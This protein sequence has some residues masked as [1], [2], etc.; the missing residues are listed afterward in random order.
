MSI[1]DL[2]TDPYNRRARL[3]PALFVML[4]ILL[5]GL[6]LYPEMEYVQYLSFYTRLFWWQCFTDSIGP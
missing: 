2:V 6:L 5:V 1:M 3:Q 4:P